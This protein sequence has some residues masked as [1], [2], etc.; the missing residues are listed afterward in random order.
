MPLGFINDGLIGNKHFCFKSD[1]VL[2]K[3][4]RVVL[5]GSVSVP[6][7]MVYSYSDISAFL[8]SSLKST[9]FDSLNNLSSRSNYR[10]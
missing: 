3:L 8:D 6:V 10:T 5:C 9:L 1:R 2:V 7:V 4:K